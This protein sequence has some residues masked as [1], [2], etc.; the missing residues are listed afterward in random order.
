M[1]LREQIPAARF[2]QTAN[3]FGLSNWVHVSRQ[4]TAYFT[5][6]AAAVCAVSDRRLPDDHN[7]KYEWPGYLQERQHCTT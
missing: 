4:S 6:P 1:T 7:G 3:Q 2:W 5:W